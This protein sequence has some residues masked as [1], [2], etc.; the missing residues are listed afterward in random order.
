MSLIGVSN[1]VQRRQTRESRF[2]HHIWSWDVVAEMAAAS[3][4]HAKPGYRDG[5]KLVPVPPGGFYCGVVEVTADTP[6]K[7]T[8]EARREGES[9]HIIVVAT[10]G[11]KLPALAVD[12]VIYRKDVLL[13]DGDEVT[14]ADWDIISVNARPTL[15]PEPMHPL[16]MARNQAHLP[17]GTKAEYTAEEYVRAILYWSTRAMRG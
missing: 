15:E 1:F 8:F 3:F 6:L 7:A 4:D 9:A 10:G 12:I 2:S 17:G 13:E 16:A 5:V 14:G 11:E